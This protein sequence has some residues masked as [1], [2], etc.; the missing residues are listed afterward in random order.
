MEPIQKGLELESNAYHFYRIAAGKVS[1]PEVQEVFKD[2][3]EK[4][5]EHFNTIARRYHVHEDLDIDRRFDESVINWLMDGIDFSDSKGSIRSLYNKAIQMEIKTRD[6]YREC[7]AIVK[8]EVEKDI[9][10][11]LAAEEDDHAAILETERDAFFGRE[12]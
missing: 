12:S 11:E 9:Y 2:F 10:R 3:M 8:S 4:E 6:F 1:D 5:I 7:Q